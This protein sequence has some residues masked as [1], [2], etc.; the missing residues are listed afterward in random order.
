MRSRDAAQ[1]EI[2]VS[3]RYGQDGFGFEELEVYR[4]AQ[5]FRASMY[6]TA[7]GLPECERFGLASQI[8]RAAVPLT[9]NIAEGYGRYS[10]KDMAH[11]CRLAR[12]SLMELLD[13]VTIC[14]AECYINPEQ[15]EELRQHARRVHQLLNGYIRYLRTQS[16][17]GHNHGEH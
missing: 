9:N 17:E 7:R 2:A 13:D 8:R 16:H 14:A 10:P 1:R 6:A 12:G 11:F 5:A 3:Q 15:R 4:Q